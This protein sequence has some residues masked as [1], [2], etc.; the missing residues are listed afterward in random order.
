MDRHGPASKERLLRTAEAVAAGEL[1]ALTPNGL[2]W[3]QAA[4]ADT[5]TRQE[6]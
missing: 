2:T 3:Q 1:R 4:A 5:I 6:W